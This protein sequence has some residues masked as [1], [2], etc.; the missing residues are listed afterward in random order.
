MTFTALWT[1]SGVL[2]AGK[3]KS[4]PHVFPDILSR[5]NCAYRSL[6]RVRYIRPASF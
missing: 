6:I 5:L 1:H 2:C 4:I 3:R